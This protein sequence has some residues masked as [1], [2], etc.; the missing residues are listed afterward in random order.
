ML[1]R[2]SSSVAITGALSLSP[3]IA[4][5]RHSCQEG[6]LE[7][8]RATKK[9]QQVKAHDSDAKRVPGSRG[10]LAT[11]SLQDEQKWQ[12]EPIQIVQETRTKPAKRNT[13][14]QQS[15]K[16]HENANI[17][18]NLR[19]IGPNLEMLNHP[20][21]SRSDKTVPNF[22]FKLMSLKR[23]RSPTPTERTITD[24]CC[25]ELPL[26]SEVREKDNAT[27]EIDLVEAEGCEVPPPKR[28]RTNVAADSLGPSS[29]HK[30]VHHISS[31]S[32][33]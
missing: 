33:H 28:S 14:A 4:K 25:D 11:K 32:P 5:P 27:S 3:S 20:K 17:A 29:S 8:P 10:A 16:M 23:S 21:K 12:A 22:D 15:D 9:R 19:P 24:E 6:L 1:A 30:K 31:V 18:R 7:P 26:I 2:T 13:I